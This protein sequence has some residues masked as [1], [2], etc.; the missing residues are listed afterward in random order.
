VSNGLVSNVDGRHARLLDLLAIAKRRAAQVG[1]SHLFQAKML[2]PNVIRFAVSPA[3]EA[4]MRQA[5]SQE[6]QKNSTVDGAHF[7]HRIRQE[8]VVWASDDWFGV[9]RNFNH[10]GLEVSC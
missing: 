9:K 1:E 10:L 6:L 3:R 5:N 8:P 2:Y 7:Q 4:V